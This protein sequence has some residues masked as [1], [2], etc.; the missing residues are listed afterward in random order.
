MPTKVP[1]SVTRVSTDALGIEANGRSFEIGGISAD[2]RYVAFSSA[3]TNLTAEISSGIFR[4]DI[5][6]GEI[7]QVAANQFNQEEDD[8]LVFN[9]RPISRSN[10]GG[11]TSSTAAISWR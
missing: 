5:K 6:T 4:K 1:L 2:G 9:P 8:D 7:V 11:F 3:A 10:S